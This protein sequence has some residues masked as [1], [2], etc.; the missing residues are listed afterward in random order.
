MA[1]TVLREGQFRLF[2]FSREEPR[3]HVHVSHPDGEAKYWLTPEV[4]LATSV[5]LNQ[6]QL[7]EAQ[8]IIEAHLGEIADA[9][10][11]HFG[12]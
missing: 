4:H 12:A 3:I 1:P 6:R 7:R 9:W 11:R 10:Q 5:G 8:S 2:F